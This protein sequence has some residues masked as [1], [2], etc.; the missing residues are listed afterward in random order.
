[1]EVFNDF[2][3]IIGHKYCKENNYQYIQKVDSIDELK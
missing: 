2:W 3:N 1:M